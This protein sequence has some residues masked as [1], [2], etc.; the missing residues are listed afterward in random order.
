MAVKVLISTLT[1]AAFAFLLAIQAR[2]LGLIPT[3][4]A[5]RDA[6]AVRPNP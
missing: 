3:L 6:A 1:L 2:W 5:R 4:D